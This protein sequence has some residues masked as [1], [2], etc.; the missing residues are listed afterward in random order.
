MDDHEP[1]E[2]ERELTKEEKK[3]LMEVL[4]AMSGQLEP[5]LKWNSTF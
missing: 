2:K 3:E 5:F 4:N 1:Q